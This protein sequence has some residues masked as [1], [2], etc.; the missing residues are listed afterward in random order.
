MNIQEEII[1]VLSDRKVALTGGQ[2]LIGTL[3]NLIAIKEIEFGVN[4]LKNTMPHTDGMRHYNTV[5]ARIKDLEQQL[6]KL[7]AKQ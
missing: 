6:L 4:E 5:V 3:A 1:E 7:K 2:S